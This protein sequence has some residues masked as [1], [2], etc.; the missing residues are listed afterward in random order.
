MAAGISGRRRATGR[1]GGGLRSLSRVAA[2]G[3]GIAG[4]RGVD[5]RIR[6]LRFIFIVFLALVGGKAVALASSSEN[7]TRIAHQ[8]QTASVVLPAHRGAILDRNGREL[9]VGKPAQTVFATPYLLDEPK[10]AA[11]ALCEALRIKKKRERQALEKALEQPKSG[12]AYVARKV[13]PDLAKAALALD[14]PG[15]GAYAEEE[16]SYPMKGSAAQVL[17]FAGIDGNGLAGVEMEY[18]KQLAGVAGSEVVVR[19]SAGK[20]TLKTVRQTQPT[21]GQDVRLTLDEDIQVMAEDVLKHTL[22]SSYAKAAVA[23]VIDPRTGEIL[24][25]ANVPEVK[26]NI[27]GVKLAADR[28][29]CVT[30]AYEPGSIFKLVTISGA[31]ADGTVNSHQR[32]TLQPTITVYDRTIHEAETRGTVNYNVKDILVHSSNVGAVTIGIKM[33]QTAMLKWVEAFGFGRDTGIAFPGES[34]GIVPAAD[35]WSGTTI[36]NVPMG[37]GIA[38]TPLQIA[39]AFAAV[40]NNGVYKQPHL[41][42]QV[43]TKVYQ[44]PSGRRV[45]PARIAAEVRQMLAAAVDHGTGVKAQIP[46]YVVAGKTGTAEKPLPDGSGYSSTNYVASFIGMVPADHPR[47]VVLVAVDSPRT[48]I[49]GGDIA[50]PAVQKIMRFALQ[51]LEIAP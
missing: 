13:D 51:Q 47:L 49:Y 30:D 40:A 9:A 11:R 17:G 39:A 44:E 8:Q 14:L 4:G 36:A 12:F 3:G 5:G 6:L 32:F 50:A 41:V 10:A 28:N 1:R 25:M 34:P 31:L 7:L 16:R 38:V 48:S 42:D 35:Q 46:G 21:A 18:D 23:V 45:I 24:A 19:D 2:R 29:R 20:K 22:S 26:D 43:G 37:Q 33:R 27:F 15:V